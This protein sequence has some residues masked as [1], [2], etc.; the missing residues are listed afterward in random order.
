MSFKNLYSKIDYFSKFLKKITI[1]KNTRKPTKKLKLIRHFLRKIVLNLK[2]VLFYPKIEKFY[3]YRK[4]KTKIL[5][6]VK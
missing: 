1:Q 6:V 2:I 3:C 4:Q 5:I